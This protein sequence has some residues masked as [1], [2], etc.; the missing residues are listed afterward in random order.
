V[1]DVEEIVAY[2]RLP[3]HSEGLVK[4]V[5]ASEYLVRVAS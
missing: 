4:T 3:I 2:K 1:D 5:K